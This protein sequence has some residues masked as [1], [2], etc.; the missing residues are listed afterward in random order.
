MV[1][2]ARKCRMVLL[3]QMT[4]D[5]IAIS[6]VPAKARSSETVAATHPIIVRLGALRSYFLRPRQFGADAAKRTKDGRVGGNLLRLQF[7]R[8][9]VSA[10]DRGPV[11]H[12]LRDRR[13]C[14][15]ACRRTMETRATLRGSPPA[16]AAAPAP[17]RQPSSRRGRLAIIADVAAGPNSGVIGLPMGRRGY[18]AVMFHFDEVRQQ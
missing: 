1:A 4:P 18:V 5:F 3:P 10:R 7:L 17:S 12:M 6:L 15:Q 13:A 8:G 16:S 2:S 9:L 14:S 11:R